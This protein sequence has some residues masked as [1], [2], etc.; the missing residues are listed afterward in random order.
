MDKLDACTSLPMELT[1]YGAT[2]KPYHSTLVH[3]QYIGKTTQVVFF[4]EAK[5]VTP[6]VKHI[7]IH[8][9]FLQEQFY[10]GLFVTKYEKSSVMQEDMCNKPCPCKIISQSTKWMNRFILYPTNDIE[11]YQLMRLHEFVLNNLGLSVS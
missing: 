2:W 7:Y 10:N 9:C 3:H 8:V 5:I 6:R 11:H 4:C 1:Q